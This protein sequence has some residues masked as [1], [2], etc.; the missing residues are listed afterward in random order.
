MKS[1]RGTRIVLALEEDCIMIALRPTKCRA[2]SLVELV[3][4]IVII[5]VI[6]A[7]AIPRFSR[8]A[9]GADESALMGNL[10]T[11]RQALELYGAEHG[12]DY[13]GKNGDGGTGAAGSEA[14]MVNQLIMF[15]DVDGKVSDSKDTT[16]KYGPYVRA[17]MPPLPVG[18][19]RG[20]RTVKLDDS[21]PPAVDISGGY[22]WIYNQDTGEIIANADDTDS[23]GSRTYDEY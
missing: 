15:S 18:A 12:G 6:A 16:Y 21:A 9:A 3:V 10:A 2:F 17:G 13:P 22:G 14:A 19:N 23:G 4:V 1:E 5:A 20:S 7:I 8:G 11:L